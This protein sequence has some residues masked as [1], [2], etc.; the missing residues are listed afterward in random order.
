VLLL[1]F[2][3]AIKAAKERQ[4]AIVK[5]DDHILIVRCWTELCV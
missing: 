2:S 1:V 4:T 3:A 5:I